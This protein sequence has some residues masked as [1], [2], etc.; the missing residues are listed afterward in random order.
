MGG[1]LLEMSEAAAGGKRPNFNPEFARFWLEVF[2]LLVLVGGII[3][4][5]W[6]TRALID[7]SAKDTRALIQADTTQVCLELIPQLPSGGARGETVEVVYR[8]G[9]FASGKLST[10]DGRTV[11]DSKSNVS[12]TAGE[13]ELTV[14][15]TYPAE[16]GP[17]DLAL[18]TDIQARP[19]RL[20]GISPNPE[21]PLEPIVVRRDFWPIAWLQIS[22]GDADA[23]ANGEYGDDIFLTAFTDSSTEGQSDTLT[24]ARPNSEGGL[25]V[26]AQPS[27][28]VFVLWSINQSRIRC[29]G[30]LIGRNQANLDV[31]VPF[32]AET[33][34]GVSSRIGGLQGNESGSREPEKLR[35]S[36]DIFRDIESTN[37]AD[38]RNQGNVARG[39]PTPQPPPT[40]TLQPTPV[41]TPSTPTPEPTIESSPTPSATVGPT[42]TVPIES[43]TPTPITGVVVVRD[44]ST[45][46]VRSSIGWNATG[47]FV[48]SGE[49]VEIS[50]SGSAG[51]SGCCTASPDGG[52]NEG[53]FGIAMDS[54]P[55]RNWLDSRLPALSLI[56]RVGTEDARYVGAYDA[57]TASSSGEL[58]L[59]MNDQQETLFDNSGQWVADV[60]VGQGNELD[61]P[62]P[63]LVSLEAGPRAGSVFLEWSDLIDPQIGYSIVVGNGVGQIVAVPSPSARSLV[64]DGLDAGEPVCLF[65]RAREEQGLGNSSEAKCTIATQAG[66][67]T[68]TPTEGSFAAPIGAT[69]IALAGGFAWLAVNRQVDPI[70]NLVKFDLT[71]GSRSNSNVD[72]GGSP[73]SVLQQ[74]DFI[75]VTVAAPNN[76]D[77]LLK[78]DAKNDSLVCD[79]VVGP[80]PF[81]LDADETGAWIGL[82]GVGAADR[83]TKFDPSCEAIGSTTVGDGP[84][85]G[86][87]TGQGLWFVNSNSNTVQLLSHAGTIISTVPVP[88]PSGIAVVGNTLFVVS[89]G[90]NEIHK[91]DA[92]TGAFVDSAPLG[93][94]PLGLLEE[95]GAIWTASRDSDQI[96]RIDPESLGVESVV[97]VGNEPISLALDNVR[98]QLWVAHRSDGNVMRIDIP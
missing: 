71:S 2:G 17:R 1:P 37:P 72:L 44:S 16:I 40:P 80:G 51:Y 55:F 68:T 67:P 65:V 43:P 87:L 22:F 3:A 23:W 69:D 19:P 85:F 56:A 83:V 25:L 46:F 66:A 52:S 96:I 70:T 84:Q 57:F 41:P 82:T 98:N 27:S 88:S 47:I 21:Q 12:I 59:A 8:F 35:F 89:A 74:D 30:S 36:P 97:N 93:A 95:G 20:V 48:N 54:A 28:Y 10:V 11:C 53:I 5:V 90:E 75:W 60:K 32:E 6:T 58:Y 13:Y 45:E 49:V 9:G 61:R 7:S 64:L 76:M 81:V 4:T 62:K 29:F 91:F 63:V 31:F 42:P 15:W 94:R 14:E 78:I 33:T 26:S 86:V 34:V 39:T 73:L 79:E 92:I 50:A 77:R 24:A 38:C 18:S